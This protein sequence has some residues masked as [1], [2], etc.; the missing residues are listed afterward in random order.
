MKINYKRVQKTVGVL[1]IFSILMTPV[2]T[3]NFKPVKD[4]TVINDG[5]VVSNTSSREDTVGKA[6][7][8]KGIPQE[9]YKIVPASYKP[10]EDNSSI[11]VIPYK[12]VSFIVDG[13]LQEEKTIPVVTVGDAVKKISKT[14]SE[15]YEVVQSLEKRLKRTDAIQINTLKKVTLN[16]KGSIKVVE[17]YKNYIEDFLKERNITLTSEDRVDASNQPIE[18]GDVIKITRTHIELT[19]KKIKSSLQEKIKKDS[20]IMKGEST[21][22]QK[23]SPKVIEESFSETFINGI[24]LGKTKVGEKV[25]SEGSPKITLVGTKISEPKQIETLSENSSSNSDSTTG[26]K[27]PETNVKINSGSPQEFAKGYINSKK[28]WGNDQFSCLVTLWNYESG[29]GVAAGNPSSGAYGIPQSLPG[30]KMA[31]FGSDWKTNPETQIKWGVSYIA[32]RYG[33]PCNALSHF[34]SHNWY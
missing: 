19:N 8:E 18:N 3:E 34:N 31:A 20:S 21:V 10:L 4:F 27:E 24:S 13:K 14:L 11:E 9:N 26:H 12:E 23:G 30:S 16:D 1:A 28:N 22:K 17:T 5:V 15:K 29:W 33:T 7:K 6:L 32:G 2:I 25:I